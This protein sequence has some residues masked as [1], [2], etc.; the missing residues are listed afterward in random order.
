VPPNA[1]VSLSS[2]MLEP[3]IITTTQSELASSHYGRVAAPRPQ[4]F[5]VCASWRKVKTDASRVRNRAGNFFEGPD[6][7][8]PMRGSNTSES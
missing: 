3:I 6:Q 1:L 8:V 2:A 5:G 4:V 7:E